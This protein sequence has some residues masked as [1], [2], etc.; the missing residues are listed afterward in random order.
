VPT[1]HLLIFGGSFD[2][3]HTGHLAIATNIQSHFH[4]DTLLFLPCNQPPHKAMPIASPEQRVKMIE[5]A[6]EDQ[7]IP[8]AAI[9]LEEIHRPGP[10]YTVDTLRALRKQYGPGCHISFLVGQDAYLSLPQWHQSETLLTLAKLLLVQ[11]PDYPQAQQAFNAG[12]YPISSSQIR[13]K[14]RRGESI[15]GLVTA[16][17]ERYIRQEGLYAVGP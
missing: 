17:V 4:F 13:E 16:R 1:T 11:R 7:P 12:L 9:S 15:Q 14:V 2:P 6:L 3:I 10:S 8:Q 5:L